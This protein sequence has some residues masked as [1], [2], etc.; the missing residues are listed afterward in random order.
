MLSIY[1]RR[2]HVILFDYGFFKPMFTHLIAVWGLKLTKMCLLSLFSD[3]IDPAQDHLHIQLAAIL[4]SIRTL[5]HH[6]LQND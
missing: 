2:E 4:Q 3:A 1:I 5:P 6:I